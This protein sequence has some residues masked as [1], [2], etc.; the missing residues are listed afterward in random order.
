MN[1]HGNIFPRSEFKVPM[2][3]VKPPKNQ[4]R[5]KNAY[6]AGYLAAVAKLYDLPP[7]PDLHAVIKFL[8]NSAPERV[9]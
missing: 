6:R 5:H 4:K 3:D 7:S 8:K 2:P 1:N 9:D